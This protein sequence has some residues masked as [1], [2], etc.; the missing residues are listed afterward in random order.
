VR[1]DLVVADVGDGLVVVVVVVCGPEPVD[2][3]RRLAVLESRR[4]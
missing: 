4:Y 2:V 3:H 1:D